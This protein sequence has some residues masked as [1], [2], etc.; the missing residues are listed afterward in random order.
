MECKKCGKTIADDVSFCT[1]CGAR[2]D[3]KKTCLKCGAV[4][5]DDMAFCPK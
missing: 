2:V 1:Y 3:D 5:E 4:I